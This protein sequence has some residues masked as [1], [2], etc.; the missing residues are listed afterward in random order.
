MKG[1][2]LDA[3]GD[4]VIQNNEIQMAYGLELTMQTIKSVLLTKTGE[5]FLDWDEG[6]D[7]DLILGQKQVDNEAVKFVVQEG[8]SQVDENLIIDKLSCDYD[9]TTRKL[10]VSCSVK[11]RN[12]GETFNVDVSV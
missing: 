10:F 6:I 7:R 8:L 4:I 2:L 11:N 3:S 1:F 12:S 5:W 9:K